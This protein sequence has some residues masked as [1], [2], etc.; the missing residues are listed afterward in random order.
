MDDTHL[1]NQVK[2]DTCFVSQD[3]R[4]DIEKCWKPEKNTASSRTQLLSLDKPIVVDYVLP[5]YHS[6]FRGK[7]RPHEPKPTAARFAGKTVVG[8]QAPMEDACV[9]GNERF[10]VPELVFRPSD[11]GMA[12]A[13][14]SEMVIQSLEHLPPGIWPAMLSNVL[15]VG[16]NAQLP[17]FVSRLETEL[18]SVVPSE[19]PVGIRC[20]ENPVT[21]TWL[22]GTRLASDPATLKAHVV[23]REDYLEHGPTWTAQQ[24][25][26]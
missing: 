22:G 11:I 7:V 25:C 5:N 19:C 20:P 10:V 26:K 6:T 17:G 21:Y 24:F 3:F 8:D 9:L 18:R 4:K 15:L 16:G 13:G 14:L 23:T 12:Q 1:V 2:E